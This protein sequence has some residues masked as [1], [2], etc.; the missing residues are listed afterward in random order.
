M[1]LQNIE[2]E[3]IDQIFMSGLKLK[4]VPQLEKYTFW[5]VNCL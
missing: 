1:P 4:K 5:F 3:K 2:F